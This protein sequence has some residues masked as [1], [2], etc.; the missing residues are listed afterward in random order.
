MFKT[1]ARD[2][3]SP[4]NLF[5]ILVAQNRALLEWRKNYLK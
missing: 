1:L 3:L 5:L 2:V 4:L